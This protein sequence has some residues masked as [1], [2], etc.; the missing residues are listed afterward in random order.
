ML[1]VHD[2]SGLQA[3]LTLLRDRMLM[4]YR[5]LRMVNHLVDRTHSSQLLTAGI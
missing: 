5:S 2:F 1:S 4:Q 3:M